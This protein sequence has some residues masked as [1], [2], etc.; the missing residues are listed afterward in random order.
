MLNFLSKNK[1]T[2][3]SQANKSISEVSIVSKTI[4][5]NKKLLQNS[6]VME[7]DKIDFI[8]ISPVFFCKNLS[9]TT[10][11]CSLRKES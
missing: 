9:L 5:A 7:S 8:E 4:N 2:D 10:K 6:C 1:L 3:L 11:N